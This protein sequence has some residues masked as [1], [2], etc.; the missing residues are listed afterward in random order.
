MIVSIP[1]LHAAWFFIREKTQIACWVAV[2]QVL[3]TCLMRHMPRPPWP[4]RYHEGFHFNTESDKPLKPARP[5]QVFMAASSLSTGLSLR[6]QHRAPKPPGVVDALWGGAPPSRTSS[7]GPAFEGDVDLERAFIVSSHSNSELIVRAAELRHNMTPKPIAGLA[8][9]TP[10]AGQGGH[11]GLYLCLPF[12]AL[13]ETV[14]SYLK[15]TFHNLRVFCQC[16]SK[17]LGLG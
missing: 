16:D 14:K 15:K 9:V 8:V 3:D 1:P 13:G 12:N 6:N 2:E 17:L 4:C 10:G 7:R 5:H 11:M